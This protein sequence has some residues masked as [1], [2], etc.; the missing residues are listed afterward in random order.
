MVIEL[1]ISS[2]IN[3]VLHLVPLLDLLSAQ[4]LDD[5]MAP[6]LENLMVVNL[7]KQTEP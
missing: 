5:A 1:A 4:I 2:A 6:D 7:E 3:S